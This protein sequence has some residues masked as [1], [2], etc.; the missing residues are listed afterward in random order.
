MKVFKGGK[1]RTAPNTTKNPNLLKAVD[2]DN[3]A[4]QYSNMLL[5][6]VKPFQS[7][8]PSL[9]ELEGLLH[10]ANIA[11]NIANM[12]QIVPDAYPLML[13]ETKKDLA[14]DKKSIVILERIIA[15]KEIKYAEENLFI[16]DLKVKS[17]DGDQFSVT[18]TAKPFESFISEE[19]AYLN[20]DSGN[21]QPGFLNRSVILITPLQIFQDFVKHHWIE[22]NP[23]QFKI[24]SYLVNEQV[25]TEGFEK[26]LKT[27]YDKILQQEL[28]NYYI[29]KNTLPKPVTLKLFKT[30]FQVN[31]LGFV[32]DMEPTP[33]E[34]QPLK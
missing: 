14:K 13:Q 17:G 19:S 33:I 27:H 30:W 9:E 34:K 12:K 4:V 6:L 2:P 24:N 11:F 20:E 5:T 29:S 10:I 21:S 23:A 16:Q 3:K 8:A 22:L 31:F 28:I 25:S 7:P 18:V 15:E 1:K 32:Y 26:W